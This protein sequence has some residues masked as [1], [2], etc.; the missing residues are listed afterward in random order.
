MSSYF[1]LFLTQLMFAGFWW[2]ERLWQ[3]KTFNRIVLGG[4]R[5]L[6]VAG[7]LPQALPPLPRS[8]WVIT[9]LFPNLSLL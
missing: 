9:V 6:S 5:H 8:M 1:F 3:I 2:I 7:D 4:C